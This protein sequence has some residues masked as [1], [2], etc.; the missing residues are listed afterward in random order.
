MN[1][2]SVPATRT[3]AGSVTS[4]HDQA[5]TAMIM[6]IAGAA[7]FGWG[8]SRPPAGWSVP[9]AAGCIVSLAVLAAGI[10]LIVGAH[11][12]PLGRLFG[13]S[14]LILSGAVL[15]AGAAAAGVAGAAP[16]ST[17]AGAGGGL[18]CLAYGV[19]CLRQALI[20][21]ARPQP[22]VT[23]PDRPA[24]HDRGEADGHG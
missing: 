9:L 21:A 6:G 12:I 7:W 22:R 4:G 17:I 24:R 2:I 14:G 19:A 23:G 1:D 20:S 10:L 13:A 11:F 16:P 3:A 8:Q 5:V 15:I 18:V